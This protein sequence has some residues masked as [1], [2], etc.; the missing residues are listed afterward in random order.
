VQEKQ[1]LEV[2]KVQRASE[3]T[4]SSGGPADDWL[5][6]CLP[7]K[8]IRAVLSNFNHLSRNEALQIQSHPL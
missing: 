7:A 8:S 2:E 3:R 5:S 6:L 1:S 4:R